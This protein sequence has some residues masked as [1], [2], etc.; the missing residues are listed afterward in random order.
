MIVTRQEAKEIL[1]IIQAFI[2]GKEI[3][4]SSKDIE[5]WDGFDDDWEVTRDPS[6]NTHLYTYRIKP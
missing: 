3:Q 4:Y 6:F 2:E 1:P 5:E